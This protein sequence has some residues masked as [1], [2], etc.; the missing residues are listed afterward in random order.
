MLTGEQLFVRG[1]DRRALRAGGEA[2]QAVRIV[3]AVAQIDP[4]VEVEKAPDWDDVV[5]DFG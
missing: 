5:R 4:G 3:E 2:L 1:V